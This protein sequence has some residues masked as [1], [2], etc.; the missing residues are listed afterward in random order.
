MRTH[1]QILA[2]AG[3]PHAVAKAIQSHVDADEV[4]LQKRVR[5]WSISSSVPGEYW[6]LLSAKG[7]ATID[8][9]ASAAARRKGVEAT[10]SDGAEA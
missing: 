4:T 6:Q 3:G 10:V 5:A 8:E 9:L 7:L 2:D 1:A